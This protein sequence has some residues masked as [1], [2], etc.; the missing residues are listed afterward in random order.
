M[1]VSQSV[2]GQTLE[3]FFT[4]R[5]LATCAESLIAMMDVENVEDL[6]LVDDEMVEEIIIAADLKLV[7]AKKFRMAIAEANGI[8]P[9]TIATPGTQA[10]TETDQT[11]LQAA[12]RPVEEVVM[13][14]IDRSGSMRC[15]FREAAAWADAGD[16]VG[17]VKRTR[18][19]AVKQ[20]FYAFRDRTESAQKHNMLGLLQ[21]DDKVEQML[22]PTTQL[23][24]FEAI[25]DDLEPRGMT[26]IFS[27]VCDAADI[28]EAVET[29]APNRIVVLTDGQS[30]CGALPHYALEAARR[31]H[32]VVDAIIVGDNPDIRLRKLVAATGGECWQINDTTEGF[33]LL[34]AESVVSIAARGGPREVDL[35]AELGDVAVQEL[36]GA[37]KAKTQRAEVK[38]GKVVDLQSLPTPS[39]DT[40]GTHLRRISKELSQVAKGDSKVW[41]Q[42][43]EGIHIFPAEDDLCTWRCL[44]E[45]PSGSPFEGGV[46]VVNVQLSTSYPYSPPNVRFE[47]PVYHCN[48]SESG[49]VCLDMLQHGWNPAL[50]VPKVLETLRNL[51]AEPDTDNALRQWVAELVLASKNS[52][53][54]DT[55]YIDQA[56]DETHQKASTSVTD[57]RATWGC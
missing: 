56:R 9:T 10:K 7:S 13:L 25:V 2:G 3:Q 52:N 44:I 45:G 27:A 1:P 55:R 12:P 14:C 4:D 32:A 34:E 6:K 48:I 29:E 50:T 57:W 39:T 15:E 41:F 11:A 43:G 19:E 46:F 53:G 54:T 24:V 16:H 28:L 18:M 36:S 47:T 42:S 35:S 5:G 21:F 26:A 37:Q 8:D 40:G 49:Q 20:M 23:D 17:Q 38:I 22:T 33:E 30:N 51:L 31:V